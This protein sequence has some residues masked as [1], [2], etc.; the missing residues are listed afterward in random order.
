MISLGENAENQTEVDEMTDATRTIQYYIDNINNTDY[1]ETYN[2]NS[3][4]LNAFLSINYDLDCLR[5]KLSIIA[6]VFQKCLA[7]QGHMASIYI[8]AKALEKK[9][10][11]RKCIT[12]GYFTYKG[13]KN[14]TAESMKL[15]NASTVCMR[16]NK[17]KK[18]LVCGDWYKNIDKAVSA[19]SHNITTDDV[20]YFISLCEP[21]NVTTTLAEAI[22][23]RKA[24]NVSSVDVAKK[25][26]KF[27]TTQVL[28]AYDKCNLTSSQ[29]E[30]IC[31]M[32]NDGYTSEQVVNEF[33]PYPKDKVDTVYNNCVKPVK[34]TPTD[35]KTICLYKKRKILYTGDMFSDFWDPLIDKYGK[36]TIDAYAEK[37]CEKEAGDMIEKKDHKIS[38][39]YHKSYEGVA[40]SKVKDS[41]R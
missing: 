6:A 14:V 13:I 1:K 35:G 5:S 32:K 37:N 30:K 38:V 36:K 18:K 40:T 22:C 27:D 2:L 31:T 28:D 9:K 8:E 33:S 41:D 10:I 17:G 20:D 29:K 34:V 39:N 4:L 7:G 15:N 21:G 24:E 16:N 19:N 23:S 11:D 26:H 25:Y 3:Q 12:T